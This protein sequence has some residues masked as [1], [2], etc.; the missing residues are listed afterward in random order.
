[1]RRRREGEGEGRREEK[2]KRERRGREEWEEVNGKREG[3][4]GGRRNILG[5]SSQYHVVDTV[6]VHL[7]LERK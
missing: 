4:K 6:L 3:N 5:Y 1:M 7:L 2:G